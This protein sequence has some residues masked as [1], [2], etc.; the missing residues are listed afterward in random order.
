MC[1]GLAPILAIIAR[2]EP[3][4]T[5]EL[6]ANDAFINMIALAGVDIGDITISRGN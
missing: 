3:Q 1:I 6:Q 5:L 4:L 2:A